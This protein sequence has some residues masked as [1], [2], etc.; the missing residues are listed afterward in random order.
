MTP[1]GQ[2]ATLILPGDTAW[3]EGSGPAPVPAAPARARVSE[4][5][6]KDAARALRSGEPAVL[7]LTGPALREKGLELAGRIAAKTGAR[8]LAQT[9]NRRMERGA[10]RVP[11]ER[12]PYP[13]DQALKTLEGVKH[14][15][16]AGSRVPVAFFAYPDKPSLLAPKDTQFTTL[17]KEDEDIVHA[18]EWLADE[19]GATQPI[20]PS[21]YDP[22]KLATGK[23]EAAT[24][25]QSLGAL[26]PENAIVVDEGVSTGRGFFPVDAPRA[27]AHLAAEHGRLDRHRHAARDRRRGRVPGPPGAQPRGRR[28]RDVHDPGAV[29]AG[30]REPQR[31]HGDLQQPLLRDPAPRADER[32][33]AECRPQGA[34]HARPRRAPI[35]TS[36][37]WRAAWAC[38]ASAS[39]RWTIST[40]RSR[41]GSPRRARISSRRC[42]SESAAPAARLAARGRCSSIQILRAV[43]ALGVLVHHTAHEVAAKTGVTV[44]FREFVVG[45]GGVDL[46]FVISGFVMVYASERLFA[47]PGASRVFFLR[48]LARIVPLYWAVTAILVGY[49]YV[50]HRIFPPPFITTEGV[51]ASFLFIPWPLPNGVMAP[52]HALGWTLNYEMFFYAVFALAIMLPRRSAVFADHDAVRA[53]R[54]ARPAGP[55]AAAVRVL[56]QPDHPRILLR[57]ADRARLARRQAAAALGLGSC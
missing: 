51:I 27:S 41:A 29:D 28:Q 17:A 44:P 26:I 36:S 30:A 45:A 53:A 6:V 5:A 11:I 43:A 20:E 3:D 54:R 2:V 52:V 48:R 35:S 34:R 24:L 39:T 14:I 12:I 47:Q 4:D 37:C 50:A 9:F 10:G 56:V 38:R 49:V 18:L 25:A 57:H 21:K 23:I 42:L 7:L 33:R 1:P 32:R 19:L 55:A 40:R 13:V 31:H 22:P 46:F 16:L 8:I 15:V